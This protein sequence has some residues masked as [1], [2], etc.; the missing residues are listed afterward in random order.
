M[1]SAEVLEQLGVEEQRGLTTAEVEQRR[2]TY[3]FNEFKR[4]PHTSLFTKFIQQ[5]AS[6]MIIVLVVA[7]VI[8]GVTGYLNGEGITDALI[9]MVI[10]VLNAI[11]GVFQESKAEKSLDALERMSAPHC[12]VV[13][14]I[15]SSLRASWW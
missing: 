11:I 6:F 2:A 9:I 8:S 7:A 12:K 3:G 1:T 13:A 14:N 15:A 4:K 5:F 10:L